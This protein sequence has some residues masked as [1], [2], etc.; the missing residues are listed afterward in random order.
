MRNAA[1]KM[2]KKKKN[3]NCLVLTE[4]CLAKQFSSHIKVLVLGY[5]NDGERERAREKIHSDDKKRHTKN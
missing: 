2:K 5:K 4:L 1:E 3:I